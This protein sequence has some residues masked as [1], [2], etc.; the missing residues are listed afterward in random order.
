MHR[1]GA[2]SGAVNESNARPDPGLADRGDALVMF[3]Q[4]VT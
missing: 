2:V 4:R 3:K 1:I